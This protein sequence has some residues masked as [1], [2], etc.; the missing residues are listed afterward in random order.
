MQTMLDIKSIQSKIKALATSH[1][2]S[3]VVLFGSQAIGNTHAQSDIDIAVIGKHVSDKSKI[4]RDFC[5]IFKRD[6]VEVVNLSNAS[7]TLMH[8]VVKDGVLLH[9][10]ENGDFLKWKLYAI[11]VWLDTAWLRRLRDKKLIDWAKTV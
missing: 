7:P 4:T 5:A 11:W 3:L 1:D 9:E 10:K 8:S 2:L 6:D